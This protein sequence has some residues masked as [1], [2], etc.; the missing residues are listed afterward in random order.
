M[1]TDERR[2][3]TRLPLGIPVFLRGVTENGD[4]ILEFASVLNISS[5]GALVVLRRYLPGMGRLSLEIPAAPM[6]SGSQLPGGVRVL[7]ARVV[8]DASLGHNQILGVRFEPPLTKTDR[9][10]AGK[11]RRQAHSD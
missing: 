8:R 6:P 11:G 7:K 3:W 5:G 2:K 10:A 4:N 1:K 9:S